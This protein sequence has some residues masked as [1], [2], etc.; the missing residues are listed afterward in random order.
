MENMI[1]ASYASI[2]VGL[3]RGIDGNGLECWYCVHV[4]AIPPGWIPYH[5]GG[6]AGK[7]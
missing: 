2:G 6:Y 5:M 1:N 3:A 4:S 7:G